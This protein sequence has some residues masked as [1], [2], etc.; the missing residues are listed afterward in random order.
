MERTVESR[1]EA[2]QAI[3]AE[4]YRRLDELATIRMDRIKV[5][6]GKHWIGW[7]SENANRTF[8]ELRAHRSRVEVFIRPPHRQLRDPARLAERA[9]STQGWGWFRSRFSVRRSGQ[10]RAAFHLL[11][12]SYEW[13]LA[14]GNG[15]SVP[16]PRRRNGQ[17]V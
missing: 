3:V 10:V 7:A 9:P 5:K 11:K 2:S 17:I 12:Q 8:A 6:Q 4:L 13:T 16:R 14:S 15:G 1:R